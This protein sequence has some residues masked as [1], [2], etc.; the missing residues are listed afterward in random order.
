MVEGLLPEHGRHHIL[1]KCWGTE[2]V[3]ASPVAH[4]PG[5]AVPLGAEAISS[6]EASGRVIF[7]LV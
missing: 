6:S 1:T 7:M 3:E 4:C 2:V 5:K